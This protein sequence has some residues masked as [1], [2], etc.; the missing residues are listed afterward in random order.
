MEFLAIKGISRS[1]QDGFVLAPVHLT[2]PK[3]SRVAVIGETGSGKTS[4]L[5]MIAGLLQPEAGSVW[6]N[7]ERIPM[8]DEKLIP[9][10]PAIAYLSQHFELR[11]N[12]RVGDLLNYFSRIEEEAAAEVYRLC[13]IDHLLQR[14]THQLSGGERQRIALARLL[15]GSPQVLVLDEPFSNLDLIHAQ[16]L[17]KVLDQLHKRLELTII[18]SS[19]N[20]LDTLSWADELLVLYQGQ[21]IQQGSPSEVYRFPKTEYVAGLLGPY[22][23]FDAGFTVQFPRVFSAHPPGGRVFTRPENWVVADGDG[24][25]TGIVTARSF[26][27]AYD[28]LTVQADSYSILVM[29]EVGASLVGANIGLQLREDSLW[30]I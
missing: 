23:L 4:L 8:A 18:L 27:G 13:E 19:H 28:L 20:P 6:L 22:S 25:I 16:H 29:T 10:H 3:S 15:V 17:K 5:K 2:M 21:L 30:M 7:G 24:V 14:W 1:A 11:N 12:Y 9:G 26:M